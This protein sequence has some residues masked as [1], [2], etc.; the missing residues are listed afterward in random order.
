[1]WAAPLYNVVSLPY[2]RQ[3]VAVS[4]FTDNG[5]VAGIKSSTSSVFTSNGSTVFD[6]PSL[7]AVIVPRVNASGQVVTTNFPETLAWLGTAG[8]WQELVGVGGVTYVHD[9]S[10]SGVA[11]GASGS[12]SAFG[13]ANWGH[14]DEQQLSKCGGHSFPVQDQSIWQLDAGV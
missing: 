4:S 6:Y 9:Q 11:V 5:W 2:G 13:F 7:G 12:S 8:V 10:D 3:T 1:M 14:V